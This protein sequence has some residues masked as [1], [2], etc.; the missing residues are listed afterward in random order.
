MRRTTSG[1]LFLN[2]LANSKQMFTKMS[3]A[4]KL[5]FIAICG[6]IIS[7]KVSAQ[8]TATWVLTSNAN[9]SPV[10]GADASKITVGAMIPGSRFTSN[11]YN[12]DGYK[13]NLS[14]S[15]PTTATDG[16]NLDFPISSNTG[17]DA[18]ITGLVFDAKTSGSSGDNVISLA[19]Q[20]DGSGPWIPFG[21]TVNAASGGSHNGLAISS[22]N[23]TLY[24]GHTYAIR[25]Y[26]YAV[27]SSTSSSRS[28]TIRN[29]KF[30]GTTTT[31]AATAPSIT[32]D[33]AR[34]TGKYT[35]LGYGTITAG[36]IPISSSGI[37]WSTNANPT[38]SD[39]IVNTSPSVTS[40]AYGVTITGL[41]PATTYHLRAFIATPAGNSYGADMTITTDQPSAPV[42]TTVDPHSFTILSKAAKSGG[43]FID[44][45][46]VAVTAKGIVFNT[47]GNP[48]Y[49]TDNPTSDGSFG[50]NYTSLLQNLTPNT[51]YY[52]RAYAINSIGTGYG[53]IDTFT[54]S[55]PQPELITSV[56]QL[57]FPATAIGDSISLTYTLSGT[58]LDGSPVTITAPD[59]FT[60]TP[61]TITY[62]GNSFTR[63]V[64]VTFAPTSL[65]FFTGEITHS[66]GGVTS[67]YI[68]NL[69]VTG[70]GKQPTPAVTSSKG[71]DFWL[72]YGFQSLMTGSNNQDMVLY[73][74]SD[75]SD[76][77]IVEIPLLGYRQAYWLDANVAI[78]T[79]F[80]PKAGSFDARLNSTGVLPKAI[81][82]Y[83]KSGKLFALYAHIFASQSSGATLVLPTNTWGTQY[84]A[85]TTGGASNSDYPHSFFFVIAD[86]DNTQIEINPS[87]D[88]TANA[89]GTTTLYPAGVPFTIT[90]NKGE[91]FN[92]LGTL[93]ATRNGDDLTGT[94][95]KSLDCNKKIALFTGNG[96]VQLS[97]GGCIYKDGG[98][99]N[100][101]QQ[102]FPK[103]AW[104]SKYLTTPLTDMEA[105]FFRVCVQDPTTVVKVNGQTID[106][107]NL[108]NQFYYQIPT[109]TALSIESDKPVMVAQ[110]CASHAC[111][112]TG[113]T[114]HPNTGNLGDPEMI[115]LS[116]VDQA[117][118]QVSVYSATR[119]AIQNNYINVIVKKEGVANFKLDGTDVS[120]QFTPHPQDTG[121]AI[122][123]FTGLQGGVSHTL[124]SDATFNAIA[125]GFTGNNDQES[126]GFNAGTLVQDLTSP[127]IIQNPYGGPVSSSSKTLK[128]CRGTSFKLAAVLPYQTNKITYSFNNN[129][130]VSPNTDTTILGQG[131]A[132]IVADS[133]FIDNGTLYYVYRLNNGYVFDATGTYGV[134]ITSFSSASIDGCP[135]GSDKTISYNVQVVEG[136]TASFGIVYNT[137][138]S[139]T[140]TLTDQSNGQGYAISQW[141]WSYDNGTKKLPTPQD[142]VQNPKLK[143]PTDNTAANYTLRVINEIGC[144]NDTTK[145]LPANP[146]PQITLNPITPNPICSNAQPVTL[147]ATPTGGTFSGRGVS[148]NTFTP[149]AAGVGL[150]TLTYTY[151][152][153]P[154]CSGTSKQTVEVAASGTLT[155]NPV[156][157]LCTT[158][159]PVTLVT[160][161]NGGVFSGNGSNAITGNTFDPSVSGAG[162][163]LIT[164]TIPNSNCTTPGQITIV[165]NN[166]PVANAGADQQIHFGDIVTLDGS[167]STGHNLAYAWT[168]DNGLTN[169]AAVSTTGKPL[170]T[171]TYTLTVTDDANCV[172]SD[173]V[174]I[175]VSGLCVFPSKSFSPNGD[176]INDKWFVIADDCGATANVNVYNRW[177]GLV[178]HSNN[179]ANSRG[180]DGTYKGNNSPDGTY[181]YVIDVFYQGKFY[182]L[183]GNVTILR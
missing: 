68:Q 166:A 126:Y 135:G 116:P 30:S 51:L 36:Q 31:P 156:N 133:T 99:D 104:G 112:G 97:V 153:G 22:L 125:Y 114:N 75:V 182:K 60:V 59:G 164:Y 141:A 24:S 46:G 180:W 107:I 177:G 138:V 118:N 161:A 146:L 152:T 79:D 144:Y 12:T 16:D 92:A 136:T 150:D 139:D 17:S 91:V 57:N 106:P 103:V 66:G 69:T 171:T 168:P 178:Y 11:A 143:N 162:T 176:G 183:T 115:I 132:N 101:I 77:I 131:N 82:V 113:L 124:S 158:S 76:S 63:V 163:F 85:L 65:S 119:Y 102:M 169:A 149:S 70:N 49:P 122:A 140:V 25:M 134:A 181:Y 130:H 89:T 111:D 29:V 105:G 165:V 83:S 19:Y 148:G 47:T 123:S 23:V 96:R 117:I 71:N 72:G 137:C 15:W 33:S 67:D 61:S 94:T 58:L 28:V 52:V 14:T 81:H 172:S 154:N 170:S 88:I 147:T 159:S 44:S 98:S 18:T 55:S 127:L 145:A 95:V 74:S 26:V 160:S 86:E 50:T 108:V 78:E 56:P 4:V 128:T 155:I 39:N 34:A 10:T 21:G 41:A 121:Y 173:D 6:L 64:T 45:G 54:T 151:S 129:S 109:D 8:F 43:N 90:L 48:S 84:T 73:L 40:G 53:D 27:S 167:A 35:A 1:N 32:S 80:L 9:A 42:L 13:C 120:A 110:F 38:L 157:P 174:N 93:L 175:E 100:F 179:Y 5:F 62:T 7:A 2:H 87:A 3:Y 37:V 142:T 20:I